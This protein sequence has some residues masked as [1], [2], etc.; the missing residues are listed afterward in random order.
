[1]RTLGAEFS[2]IA[3]RSRSAIAPRWTPSSSL[4]SRIRSFGLDTERCMNH[5]VFVRCAIGE[6]TDGAVP[7]PQLHRHQ[8]FSGAF[9]PHPSMT[10]NPG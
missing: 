8:G 9:L 6:A 5:P 4:L 1:V 3:S 10:G 2:S 7:Q